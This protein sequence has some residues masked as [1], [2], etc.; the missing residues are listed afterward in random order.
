MTPTLHMKKKPEFIEK[1]KPDWSEY[2]LTPPWSYLSS[3]QLA[4]VLGVHLQSISNYVCRGFL[5]PE[6]RERFKGNKNYFRISYIRSLFE[7]KSE[8]QIQWEWIEQ[9]MDCTKP[10][11][12]LEQAQEV[13]RIA[14]S[15]LGI[16]KP[17]V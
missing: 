16:N 3:R 17:F 1:L 13:A 7:G 11:D 15:A 8:E 10:F 9:Y 5:N 14:Y 12:S 2:E 6:P 4:S